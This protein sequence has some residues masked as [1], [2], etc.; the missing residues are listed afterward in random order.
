M[1]AC[2]IE[3]GAW[4]YTSLRMNLSNS[5][6]K[7]ETGEYKQNGEWNIYATTARWKEVVLPSGPE[8]SY[9]KVI[10]IM[11]LPEGVLFEQCK[12]RLKT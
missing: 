7:M 10:F 6:F 1:Q 4:A 5:D 9:S 11:S 8:I 2:E 3:I 12:L